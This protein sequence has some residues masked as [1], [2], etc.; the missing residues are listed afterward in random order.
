M[1]ELNNVEEKWV[2]IEEFPNYQ[3]S[4]LGRIFNTKT[5]KYKQPS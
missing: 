5:Q 1:S 2:T 4:N 3:I